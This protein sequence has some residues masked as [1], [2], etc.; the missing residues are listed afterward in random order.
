[1]ESL[2]TVRITDRFKNPEYAGM[3]NDMFRFVTIQVAIQLMLVL[4]DPSRFSF[5]SADFVILLMFVIIG[6]MLYWLV[7][8][9]LVVFL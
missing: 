4:M 2:Y 9:K 8:K 1:M 6:V 3:L 7:I 5:F